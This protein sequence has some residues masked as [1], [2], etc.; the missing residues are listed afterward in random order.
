MYVRSSVLNDMVC[1]DIKIPQY[2]DPVILNYTCKF[3]IMPLIN[4]A[5]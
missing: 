4:L 1:L 3:V 5:N 2:F